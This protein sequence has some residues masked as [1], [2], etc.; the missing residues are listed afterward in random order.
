M[1][2][3]T[4]Q[5]SDPFPWG[6]A[7]VGFTLVVDEAPPWA[8]SPGLV[9]CVDVEHD[10]DEN[11]VGLAMCSL[12]SRT[13]YY[14]TDLSL[15]KEHLQSVQLLGHN[16]KGD[17]H[18]LRKWGVDV[19]PEQFYGDTMLLHYVRN[20]T[21]DSQGLKELSKLFLGWEW[22]SYR[23]MV[24]LGRT[25]Q[26]LDKQEVLKV[27]S[28]CGMD[29][30]ATLVLHEELLRTTSPKAV[31]Y[32]RRLELP[33]NRML[34]AMELEGV[35]YSR[36]KAKVLDAE[37]V[38]ELDALRLFYKEKLGVIKTTGKR[39]IKQHYFNPGSNDQI[40]EVLAPKLGLAIKDAQRVTLE[41]F[42]EIEAIAKLLRFKELAK[43]QG[44]Y[45]KKLAGNTRTDGRVRT[46]FNQISSNEAD[47]YSKGI[48]T[49]RLSSSGDDEGIGLHQI[50]TRTET[51]NQLRY[52]FEA[53]EGYAWIAADYSQIEY[54]LLAHFTQEPRLLQAFNDG[55]DV[56]QVTADLFKVDRRVG[57][58]LNFAAIYGA[59][60]KRI[61][62]NA[63]ITEQRADEL[64]SG[65]WDKL[66]KVTQW[67]GLIKSRA[68]YQK[69]VTTMYGRWI[70]LPG[71]ASSNKWERLHWERAAVN[72]VIQGSA[73]E[74]IKIAMLKVQKR[75]LLPVLQVH[76][77]LADICKLALVDE[78]EVLIKDCMESVVKLRVP[79]I[80][81]I[82]HGKSWGEAKEDD[83]PVEATA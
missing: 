52:L 62:I 12:G 59:Q 37:F 32:Y 33:L 8:K 25:K 65:Y 36:D 34:F 53:P 26:T 56:H 19:R 60:A 76:D 58:T 24:G 18:L 16:L 74:I 66:P 55:V 27:A 70:P 5:V 78:H 28:Y 41:P 67:I 54:R 1:Q 77:E 45:T 73:A 14:V 23:L 30:A 29:C 50:P 13:L 47:G 3:Q 61:A 72:Y 48:R 63:K 17:A 2:K 49:G 20:S 43:L 22:P 31:D 64:L 51:G 4:L 57:K 71:I 6:P 80:A 10:E 38:A 21:A 81:D 69:G 79:L 15:A 75:E 35:P 44:T 83:K 9:V 82:G 11:F 46:T 39:V 42:A 40:I 7:S 68:L